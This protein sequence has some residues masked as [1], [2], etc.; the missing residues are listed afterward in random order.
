MQ[1][2]KYWLTRKGELFLVSI[3]GESNQTHEEWAVDHFTSLE[4]LLANGWVRIQFMP[5]EYLYI[6]FIKKPNNLQLDRLDNLACPG[7]H[8]VDFK[9][10]VVESKKETVEFTDPLDFLKSLMEW[11]NE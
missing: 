8:P 3:V 1:K 11:S 6:D 4:R 10:I 7:N 9:K 5:P 2:A